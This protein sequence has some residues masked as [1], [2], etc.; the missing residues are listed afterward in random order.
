MLSR[1]EIIAT[2]EQGPD[3]VVSLVEALFSAFQQQFEMLNARIKELEDQLSL[4]SQN[5]SKPPSS[6]TPAQRPKSLRTP[7][8]KMPG[9]QQ[10]HSGKTLKMSP[11]PDRVVDHS[12]SACHNC[13]LNL[14]LTVGDLT[15]DQRQ[16]FDLPPL[17]IEITEH[18]CLNKI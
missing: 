13:G 18:R 15:A 9:A 2:Y 10:V 17:K 16:V 14:N 4:N 3:A 5:S 12:A 11:T 7:S 1:E 8:S 6:N